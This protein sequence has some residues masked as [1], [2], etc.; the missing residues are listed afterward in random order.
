[1][2]SQVTQSQ[3]NVSKQPIRNKYIKVELL[4]FNYMTVGELQGNVISGSINIDANSDLRRSCTLSLVV[5]DSSFNVEAGGKIW[6]DKLIKIQVGIDSIRTGQT[7][8]TKMGIFLINQPS[9]TYDAKTHT[10]SFQGV[11]LAAKLTGLRNGYIAGLGQDDKVL[12]KTGDNIRQNIIG[13]LQQNGIKRYVVS[14]CRNTDGAIQPVPYDMEFEQGSTW[15]D[16]IAA[17]RD[18]LPSYQAYF[19]VDGVFRYEPIPMSAAD[20]IMVDMD[21]WVENVIS[22][23]V[24]VDFESVKNV[25]E[26]Y[27]VM[28]DPQYFSDET[29][30]TV[31]GANISMTVAEDFEAKE[32]VMIGFVL[33]SAVSGNI[34]INV[35]NTG[36]K[37]LV[38]SSGNQITSLAANTYWV[39]YYQANGTWLFLGHVQA[40]AIWQDTNPQSPFYINGP[41]G[42]IRIPLYGDNYENIQSDELALERAKYEIYLRCRLND[43]ISIT[44]VPIYYLDVNWK[45]N[46]RPLGQDIINQYIIQSISIDLSSGGKQTINMSRFYPLYPDLT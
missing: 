4:D 25:V 1:M 3:Y 15:W 24:N 39:A 30:T 34:T 2:A 6:L 23:S 17:L 41:I 33:P 35:N 38:N 26:V 13:V 32:Y 18:I 42:Q 7:V 19:D 43:S 20:P 40:Q 12:I 8:W 31:S 29:K 45:T 14:E 27:G 46:Y 9:Y 37:N 21:T 10:L 44:T 36:A 22:D 11:D 5:T 28:H 16:V